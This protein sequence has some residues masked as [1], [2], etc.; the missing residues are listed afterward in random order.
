MNYSKSAA[1]STQDFVLSVN[2]AV[3]DS[4]VYR[5]GDNSYTI[6]T[7]NKTDIV[8]QQAVDN[9]CRCCAGA[10]KCMGETFVCLNDPH[11]CI[12]TLCGVDAVRVG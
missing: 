1:F 11:V 8:V 3:I 7:G 6:G 10:T 9:G 12:L 5:K 2:D 4:Y